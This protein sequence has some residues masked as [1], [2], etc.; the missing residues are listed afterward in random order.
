MADNLANKAA[1][2]PPHRNVRTANFGEVVGA[3]AKIAHLS[4]V[5]SPLK[6]K[7]FNLFYKLISFNTLL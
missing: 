3:Q 4:F 1:N 5:H 2:I 7:N 6:S